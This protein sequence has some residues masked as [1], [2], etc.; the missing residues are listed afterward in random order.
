[1]LPL[2]TRN[3][4]R[5]LVVTRQMLVIAGTLVLGACGGSV[6]A[7]GE[8]SG[9]GDGAGADA[10]STRDATVID[11]RDDSTAT[12]DSPAS[13]G[14]GPKE[15]GPVDAAPDATSCPPGLV[16]CDAG[17][18]DPIDD[19]SYCGATAGC[20]IDGGTAGTSCVDDCAF[21][22][23]GVCQVPCSAGLVVCDGTCVD[24][25]TSSQH[26]GATCSCVEAGAGTVCLPPAVCVSG[27]CT[28]G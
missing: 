6:D 12:A 24:P 20:G 1:M 9:T 25:R 22:V 2:R 16:L 8:D 15:A 10:P 3:M 21:C 7:S 26:C 17:C 23:G 27:M 5:S 18:I 4:P 14:P 19:P 28:D 13:D 11:A